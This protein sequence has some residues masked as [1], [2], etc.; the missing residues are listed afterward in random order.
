MA[1]RAMSSG[2]T[3][4]QLRDLRQGFRSTVD[5]TTPRGKVLLGEMTN[6]ILGRDPN[7]LESKVAAI[8]RKVRVIFLLL[9]TVE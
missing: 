6:M 8:E 1:E 9:L 5:A 4:D 7:C 2:K 3:A